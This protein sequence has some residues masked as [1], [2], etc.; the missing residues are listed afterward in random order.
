MRPEAFPWDE[1]MGFLLGVLRWPPEAAW[2]A[3][4]REAE[5]AIAGR[6]GRRR[7]EPM[8]GASLD[9]LM[10][11]YPDASDPVSPDKDEDHGGRLP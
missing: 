2:G 3:T 7:A 8:D 5:M 1:V 6:F 11:A 10:A 9:A 4:P